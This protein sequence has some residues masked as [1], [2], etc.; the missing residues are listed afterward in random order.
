MVRKQAPGKHHA[1]LPCTSASHAP[2]PGSLVCFHHRTNPIS[3]LRELRWV[4]RPTGEAPARQGASA[5]GGFPPA[6]K[7][8]Q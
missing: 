8:V 4:Y 1:S 5:F 6:A 3:S 7:D 2:R